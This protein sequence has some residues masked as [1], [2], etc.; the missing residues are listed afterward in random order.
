MANGDPKQQAQISRLLRDV[1]GQVAPKFPACAFILVGIPP[2]RTPRVVH[3]LEE[4][5]DA[6]DVMDFLVR[7]YRA[8]EDIQRGAPGADGGKEGERDR[9]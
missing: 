9:T 6:Y 2:D 7:T 1:L 8:N 4:E 5:G 3:N